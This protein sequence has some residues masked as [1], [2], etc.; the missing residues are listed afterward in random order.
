MGA[1]GAPGFGGG[2]TAPVAGFGGV[3]AGEPAAGV[4]PGLGG[5]GRT[6][7]FFF[8]SG[9]SPS[10]PSEDDKLTNHHFA[11]WGCSPR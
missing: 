2:G 8:S 4:E 5:V 11:T 10:P 3:V 6:E 1:I 9:F 7:G